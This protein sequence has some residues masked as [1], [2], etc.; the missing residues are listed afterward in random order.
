LTLGTLWLLRFGRR[1]AAKK[2]KQGEKGGEPGAKTRA[3]GDSAD[4]RR[5]LRPPVPAAS[6]W[7]GLALALVLYSWLLVFALRGFSLEGL[8][9]WYLVTTLAIFVALP[10]L[11]GRVLD[12]SD[13]RP[14]RRARSKAGRAAATEAKVRSAITMVTISVLGASLV[15]IADA[16]F[17]AD[18]LPAAVV[19]AEPGNCTFLGPTINKGHC[20]FR[21][22]YMGESDQWIFLVWKPSREQLAEV[23]AQTEEELEGARKEE[24]P[25]ER[26]E[27]A[28]HQAA[29]IR[30]RLILIPRSEVLQVLVAEEPDSLPEITRR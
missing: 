13:P 4:R 14:R 1:P 19:S 10:L 25:T 29:S 18:P 22:Y 5:V 9:A 27:A 7:A 20:Y 26:E 3:A 24:G 2:R 6:S 16:G 15:R 28:Q 17:L 23:K 8:E 11:A 30:N 12:R 21:G